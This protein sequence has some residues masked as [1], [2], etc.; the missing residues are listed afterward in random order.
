MSGINSYLQAT[1]QTLE[2]LVSCYIMQVAQM[3]AE[4]L[5]VNLNRINVTPNESGTLGFK[6][7]ILFNPLHHCIQE[8]KG[9]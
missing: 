8:N 9:K 1:N 2:A 6:T 5:K 3:N 4:Y 7:R